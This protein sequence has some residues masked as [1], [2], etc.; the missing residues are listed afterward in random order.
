M[1]AFPPILDQNLA[2]RL[3]MDEPEFA[4]LAHRLG[5]R[6]GGRP[7]EDADFERALGY[8][9]ERPVESFLMR[10]GSVQ[11][12]GA[13]DDL[14]Q[15]EL[16]SEP[17]YP[18]IAFGSNGAPGVLSAKLAVL[19][20]DSRDVLALT[21]E[22]NGY[23]IVAS[24]HVAIYGALPATIIPSAQ[25]RVRAGLL[26]VTAEQFTALTRTEFN[27]AVARID[28]SAF[29]PDLEWS[30]P[31]AVFAYVSRNGAFTIEGDHVGLKAIPASNRS[32]H[33]LEQEHVLDAAAEL[34]L[35]PE[36]SALD[37]VREV[38]ADYAWSIEVARPALAGV[39]NPFSPE[40]WQL[41]GR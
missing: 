33:E 4:E 17:R 35:G 2:G 40:D 39:T 6:L 9:W 22:L 29:T 8:P 34:I 13:G 16:G 14:S 30:A 25:T 31:D 11:L 19:D 41:L 3:A 38:I 7:M 24:A 23:D 18:L 28:G 21:G 27:Y 10:D 26:M 12:L 32:C 1:T 20:E 37:V 36:A 5:R 15:L